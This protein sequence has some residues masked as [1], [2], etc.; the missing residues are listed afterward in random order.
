M[1]CAIGGG[2]RGCES[3]GGDRSSGDGARG[4]QLSGTALGELPCRRR[5]GRGGGDPPGAGSLRRGCAAAAAEL[6]P[7]EGEEGAAQPPHCAGDTRPAGVVASASCRARARRRNT[8]W[9]CAAD[10]RPAALP[11]C[12]AS[13]RRLLRGPVVPTG[14]ER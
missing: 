13:G 11:S 1:S 3:V 12:P 14:R 9:V 6:R 10:P 2:A 4:E 5:A 8:A 7:P